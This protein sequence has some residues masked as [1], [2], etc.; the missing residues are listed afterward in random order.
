MCSQNWFVLFKE[1]C[2][3][4]IWSQAKKYFVVQNP[5]SELYS[6]SYWKLIEHPELSE[7]S[8]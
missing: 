8:G 1:D 2:P 5:Q 7:W 4:D 6:E 3:G